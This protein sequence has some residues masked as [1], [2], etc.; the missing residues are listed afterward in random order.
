MDFK[1][2][3][4]AIIKNDDDEVSYIAEILKDYVRNA[5][6]WMSYDA[7]SISLRSALSDSACVDDVLVLLKG[8]EGESVNISEAVL[9][10]VRATLQ[11]DDE[12]LAGDVAQAVC[13]YKSCKSG[14]IERETMRLTFREIMWAHGVSHAKNDEF[15][16]MCE[17]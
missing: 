8:K 5:S 11:N 16:R 10:E 1:R 2:D 15:M 17:F 3:L 14:W 13:G 4:A 9:N 6:L 7:L 12:D